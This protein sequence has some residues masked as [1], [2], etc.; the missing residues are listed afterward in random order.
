[1]PRPAAGQEGRH[2]GFYPLNSHFLLFLSLTQ[3]GDRRPL[4]KGERQRIFST[5]GEHS[6]LP[7]RNLY[8][9]PDT[10]LLHRSA[11]S[12]RRGMT[13]PR[14]S[15]TRYTA[16]HLRIRRLVQF[17]FAG[18]VYDNALT[19]CATRSCCACVDL[20]TCVAER[21]LTLRTGCE[22]HGRKNPLPFLFSKRSHIGN[23]RQIRK[24]G[25][26]RS[27]KRKG[28]RRCPFLFA[29]AAGAA[30]LPPSADGESPAE[31]QR[32]TLRPERANTLT[33]FARPGQPVQKRSRP[34]GANTLTQFACPGFPVQEKEPPRQGEH[35]NAV[36]AP[37]L[38]GAEKGAAHQG[39]PAC[40]SSCTPHNRCRKGAALSGRT[41]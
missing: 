10:V 12:S 35:A 13:V 2:Q 37:R 23:L 27:S 14:N 8:A 38:S 26:G 41:R 5:V 28:N 24:Q 18:A 17:I 19:N 25:K 3:T 16:R 11:T 1:M 36:R 9:V 30:T 39:E 32:K 29:P 6:V 21:Y 4:R 7:C 33:Q 20:I 22:K 40:G 15:L 31:V 34:L